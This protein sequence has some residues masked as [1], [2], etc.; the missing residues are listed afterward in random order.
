LK[1]GDF[2]VITKTVIRAA[3][4]LVLA[5][6][7]SLKTSSCRGRR[8]SSSPRHSCIRGAG[9]QTRP[10]IVEFRLTAEEKQIVIDDAG[11][12]LQAMTFNGSIPHR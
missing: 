12:K 1:T 3:A 6:P 7:A 4:A 5:A 11:T 8:S 2:V 10:K 9:D